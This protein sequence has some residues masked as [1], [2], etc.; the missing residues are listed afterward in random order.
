M[1]FHTTY[2]VL[3]K[4]ALQTV[5]NT[6]A[7]SNIAEMPAFYD[8]YVKPGLALNSLNGPAYTASAYINLLSL[9]LVEGSRLVGRKIHVFSYGSGQAAAMFQLTCKRLPIF[10]PDTLTVYTRRVR[11]PYS[12]MGIMDSVVNANYHLGDYHT[13]DHSKERGRYYLTH[14]DS[15]YRRH[16]AVTT[17][18]SEVVD[19]VHVG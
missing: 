13:T 17:Q 12:Y 16:Y 6:L 4:K 15:S 1:V 19:R 5:F 18:I 2:P 7:P 8:T 3:A 11:K 9:I 14:V 10:D